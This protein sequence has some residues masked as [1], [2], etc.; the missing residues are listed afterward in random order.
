MK[1]RPCIDLHQGRVKQIVGSTLSDN[2]DTAVE[3]FVSEHNAAFYAG[4]FKKDTLTGGHVIMLG[5]GNDNEAVSALK[6]FPGGLQVG[7]GINP[8][9]A[10]Y[11]LENG[12]SHVIVTSYLFEGTVFSFKKLETLSERTGKKR[13]VL[14]FSCRKTGGRYMISANRWKDTTAQELDHGFIKKVEGF[15]DELL[16]HA[17][18][19]EG[20][21]QGVDVEL[22]ENLAGMASIPVT[23]AGG[24]RSI[25][26]IELVRKKGGGKIDFTVGSALDLFGGNLS[27]RELTTFK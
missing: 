5:K 4:L 3:N 8:D 17:I 24:I 7:G 1:F 21:R 25:E 2:A 18:D 9:N 23:Y 19:L 22:I 15:C 14:D 27:Y 12:A 26:D 16:I 10:G 6:A 13:L 11:Y 20:K